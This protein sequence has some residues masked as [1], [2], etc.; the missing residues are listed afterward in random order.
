MSNPRTCEAGVARQPA[1]SA[2]RAV[3]DGQST[4]PQSMDTDPGNPGV[5]V[6]TRPAPSLPAVSTFTDEQAGQGI[7]S[8]KGD[9]LDELA[10]RE[11]RETRHIILSANEACQTDVALTTSD[12]LCPRPSEAGAARQPTLPTLAPLR[13]PQT[14][15]PEKDHR[16]GTQKE[17]DLI[18]LEPEIISSPWYAANALEPGSPGTHP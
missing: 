4:T 10:P 14:H 17:E 13:L 8:P 12:M 7:E 16:P 2:S 3:S 6:T 18:Q 5:I 9:Q 11:V 1:E 15:T